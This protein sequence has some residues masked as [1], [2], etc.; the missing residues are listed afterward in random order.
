MP[1]IG[2]SP[3]ISRMISLKDNRLYDTSPIAIVEGLAASARAGERQNSNF[4]RY[5]D[6]IFY[7]E[8]YISECGGLES[9]IPL[10]AR[11]LPGGLK[12]YPKELVGLSTHNNLVA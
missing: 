1:G 4:I 2:R 11:G 6:S 5:E 10:M 12:I 8:I 3:C 9:R 7:I